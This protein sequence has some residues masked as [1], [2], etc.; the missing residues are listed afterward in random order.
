ME[1]RSLPELTAVG[2]RRGHTLDSGTHL[3][4]AFGSAPDVDRPWG[5]GF[6]SR[7]DYIEILRYAAARHIEVIPELEMPGHARAAIKAMQGNPQYRLNDPDDRSVYTSAQGYHDNVMNPALESTY[8]FVER[9]VGDLVAI[10]REAG[11]PLRHIH[12]G[13]DEVPAGVWQ[14]SPAVQAYMQAPKLTSV[15][16]LWFPFFGRVEQLLKAQGSVPPGGEKIPVRK[17]SLDAH[18]TH[19]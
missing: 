19:I 17:T 7:A 16:D 13:G 14:G 8:R 3:P 6:F 1:R 18:R 2:A 4:P 5:S 10:H 11:V 12:M 15:D 9:V